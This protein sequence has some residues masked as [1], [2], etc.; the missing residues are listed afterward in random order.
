[1]SEIVIA[2][3]SESEKIANEVYDYLI[4]ELEK[5]MK[6]WEG[7]DLQVTKNLVTLAPN[8]VYVSDDTCMPEETIKAILQS[9]LKSDPSRFDNHDVIELTGTFTT[10]KGF[11]LHQEWKCS[12][13]KFADFTPTTTK[14]CTYTHSMT[15]FEV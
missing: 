6:K 2:R 10:G 3:V 4:A 14:S 7:G 13:L 12:S 1:L 5:R 11:H 15:H 8:E 9:I